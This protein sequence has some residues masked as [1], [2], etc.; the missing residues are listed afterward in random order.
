VP[1]ISI[2]C[3]LDKNKLPIGLQIIAPAFEEK[4]LLQIARMFEKAT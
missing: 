2:P 4:K 3:G 1:A